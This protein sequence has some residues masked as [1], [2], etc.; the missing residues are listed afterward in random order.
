MEECANARVSQ[1]KLVESSFDGFDLVMVKVNCIPVQVQDG[2]G[3]EKGILKA[4][5][6]YTKNGD[7]SSLVVYFIDLI[8]Y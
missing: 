2:D 8:N 7:S 5:F 1:G 3:T 6:S 4:L